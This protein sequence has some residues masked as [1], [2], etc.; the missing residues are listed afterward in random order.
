MR[1]RRQ[2]SFKA[3]EANTSD[4]WDDADDDLMKLASAARQQLSQ[5]TI[6][7]PSSD[8][9]KVTAGNADSV[10]VSSDSSELSSHIVSSSGMYHNS[11]LFVLSPNIIWEVNGHTY[12]QSYQN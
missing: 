9:M 1:S 3:F 5:K 4:A 8:G 11:L 12:P 2:D 10:N 6:K 7:S